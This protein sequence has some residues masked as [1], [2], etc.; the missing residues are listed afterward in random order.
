MGTKEHGN[1]RIKSRF[2][3]LIDIRI[4]VKKLEDFEILNKWIIVCIIFY[5]IFLRF[6]DGWDEED[7]DV[8][9]EEREV[10]EVTAT[11]NNLI[12]RKRFQA[13]LLHWVQN[14]MLV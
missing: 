8:N 14:N 10:I 2:C 7:E 5:N 1:G 9:E 11:G 4:R 3:S 6:A 12:L 13:D